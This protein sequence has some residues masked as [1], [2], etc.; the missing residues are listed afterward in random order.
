MTLQTLVADVA[1]VR[2]MEFTIECPEDRRCSDQSLIISVHDGAN[3][4]TVCTVPICTSELVYYMISSNPL[5]ISV[6]EGWDDPWIVR[7]RQGREGDTGRNFNSEFSK[8]TQKSSTREDL[9]VLTKTKGLISRAKRD[10]II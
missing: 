6:Q 5:I 4:Y 7:R 1:A 10:Y 9:R 2:S 3:L 8:Y